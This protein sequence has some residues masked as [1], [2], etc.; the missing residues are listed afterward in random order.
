M[1]DSTAI[2][3]TDE[4]PEGVVAVTVKTKDGRDA[5]ALVPTELAERFPSM[6]QA[7]ELA[8]LLAEVFE[9][10][11]ET[12]SVADLPRAKV[13]SGESKS[14]QI[15]DDDPVRYIK[16]IIVVRQERRNYWE[17][18]ISE[19]GGGQ[20][21]DCFSRD[22]VHGQGVNGQG[23]ADNPTGLCAD[24]PFGQWS[25][26]GD[27]RV[28]PPCKPQ[29][30][31]LV[32]TEE[33]AFPLLLTV[34]RTSQKAL[35]DYV[36]RTLLA[37]KMKSPVEVVTKIGMRQEQNVDKVTYNILTFEIDEDITAG[38]TPAQKR[39]YKLAPLAL[40]EEFKKILVNIDTS[41]DTEAPERQ[42]TSGV[43]VDDEGGFS[44]ADDDDIA[45]EYAEQSAG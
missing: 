40:G 5:R 8:E 34:P 15:G 44:I 11:D 2:A 18:S 37:K 41:R 30:A 19:G 14:F 35:R 3:L 6:G 38:M 21:P 25:E 22:G 16:G 27:D 36:K 13:P 23:S 31:V 12:L 26:N 24:C 45:A 20:A 39:A 33:S 9:D 1:S 4:T 10:R 29:E 43:T 7:D 28:P 17:K 42:N 32:L